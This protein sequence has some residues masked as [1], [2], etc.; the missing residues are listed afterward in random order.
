MKS[1]LTIGKVLKPRGLK[2]EIKIETYSSDSARF[3]HLKQLT[4][5]GCEYRINS[6]SLE[7]AIGYIL[8][9]GIDS[10]EKAEALRGKYF[11]AKKEDLPELPEGKYYIADMIGLDVFANGECLGEI[12]DVLQYG[13]ADV[14]VVK[15][16]DSSLSFPAINGLIKQVDLQD[17]KMYVDGT[18]LNRVVVFN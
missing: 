6:I 11:T 12:I 8:V 14:Y 3:S 1:E 18:I 10:V 9:E 13:S 5:D 17:G 4:I 16:L 7:G 2:G 15:T